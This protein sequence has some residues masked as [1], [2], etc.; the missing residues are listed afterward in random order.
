MNFLSI[1]MT[2]FCSWVIGLFILSSC[3]TRQDPLSDQPEEIRN[4]TVKPMTPPKKTNLF[5]RDSLF[6]DMKNHI[7]FLEGEEGVVKIK[8]RVLVD[9]S[10]EVKFSSKLRFEDLP[11]GASYNKKTGV[12]SWAPKK[13]FIKEGLFYT[14]KFKV[15]LIVSTSEEKLAIYKTIFYGVQKNPGIP[16]VVSIV[17]LEEPLREGE[18]KRSFFVRVKDNDL[19]INSKPP[20]LEVRFSLYKYSGAISLNFNLK[21]TKFIASDE[22]YEYHYEIKK[23]PEIERLT[24]RKVR[25]FVKAI[26]V[27]GVESDL[28]DESV[29]FVH[30][31]DKPLISW[32]KGLSVKFIQGMGNTFSFIVKDPNREGQ[33]ELD[34]IT[35]CS[36][37]SVGSHCA[38]AR[39]NSHNLLCMLEYNVPVYREGKKVSID[40]KVRN[41]IGKEV[42]PWSF[43]RRII[44]LT[45]F[46]TL[47]LTSENS[48]KEEQ[49][50][51]SVKPMKEEQELLSVKSMKEELLPV[52]FDE[53]P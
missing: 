24:T 5:H 42:T 34:F 7:V 33:V 6:I 45:P 44:F 38:C 40:F 21:S 52:G 26:S 39:H 3:D 10:S 28:K 27:Y 13:G 49:E 4:A 12:L 2:Y 46:A 22:V 9:P 15:F 8:S 20:I 29:G 1:T 14:G 16:E 51:L 37:L 31:P 48:M 43:E 23:V 32:P 17:G 19:S 47:Q 18:K 11:E 53:Q 30:T 41:T 36:K 50:L 25:C 35:N